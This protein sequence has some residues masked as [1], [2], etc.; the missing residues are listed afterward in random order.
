MALTLTQGEAMQVTEQNIEQVVREYQALSFSSVYR[1][2]SPKEA[3]RH[4]E[5][6]QALEN[7][8]L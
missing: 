2:L 4:L 6:E 8:E 7:I 3:A 1:K 5:L